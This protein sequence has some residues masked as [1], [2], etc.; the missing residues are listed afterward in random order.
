MKK[1]EIQSYT[2]S[3]DYR[4]HEAVK[5]YVDGEL[6]IDAEYGGEPEDNSRLRDYHWVESGIAKIAKLLGA[7]VVIKEIGEDPDE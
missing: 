3:S 7:E 4:D 5:V 2:W 6:A 1:V